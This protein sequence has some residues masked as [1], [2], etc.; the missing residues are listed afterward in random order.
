MVLRIIESDGGSM[1]VKMIMVVE[2]MTLINDVTI[3]ST[4]LVLLMLSLLLLFQSS[5]GY[6][7]TVMVLLQLHC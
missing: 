3:I 2:A 4:V 6:P 5:S 1:M 7:F